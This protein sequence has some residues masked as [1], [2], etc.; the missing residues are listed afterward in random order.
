V[1]NNLQI[2]TSLLNLQQRALTDESAKA[3]LSDTRQRITALAL[4]YRQLY[5][6]ADLREVEVRPF[7]EE[8]M[9]QLLNGAGPRTHPVRTEIAS[10]EM[11]L[12][13]DKIAPFALF[14]VEAVTNALK[15]A[16]PDRTGAIAVRFTV[17]GPEARLEIADDGVGASPEAAAGGVGSTLMTAFARQLRGRAEVERL[18][19][20]GTTARLIFPTPE[21]LEAQR[22]A[23]HTPAPTPS[24]EGAPAAA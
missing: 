3:A 5:Q 23:P 12:D 17:R 20:G 14:L 9:A 7:L 16:F 8:L 11:A 21:A 18:E 24:A 13:P 22:A 15:H 1:K 2:I 4:I 10:D 19:G 6:G